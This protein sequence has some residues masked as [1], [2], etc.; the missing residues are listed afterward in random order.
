[1]MDCNINCNTIS[2]ATRSA[3]HEIIIIGGV[4]SYGPSHETDIMADERNAEEQLLSQARLRSSGGN[5]AG[6]WLL[7]ISFCPELQIDNKGFCIAMCKKPGLAKKA[8]TC[9]WVSLVRVQMEPY[10]ILL[11][12]R[13]LLRARG[14]LAMLTLCTPTLFVVTIPSNSSLQRCSPRMPRPSYSKKSSCRGP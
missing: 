11:Q 1:M 2:I 14:S 13:T 7:A 8:S 12:I 9:T 10:F 3:V 5:G 4:A 6:D